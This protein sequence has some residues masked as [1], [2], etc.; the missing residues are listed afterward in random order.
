MVI[1]GGKRDK[2][3]TVMT[4]T[5]WKLMHIDKRKKKVVLSKV[6]YSLGYCNSLTSYKY[7]FKKLGKFI[8]SFEDPLLNPKQEYLRQTSLTN[9]KEMSSGN[10]LAVQQLA[11]H[12]FTAEGTSSI[13]GHGTK[14]PQR[15]ELCC[16]QV[17]YL[18]LRLLLLQIQIHNPLSTSIF[19]NKMQNV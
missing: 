7:F 19:P 11:L 16:L 1:R 8:S 10:S 9:L 13:P 17:K 4:R 12:T 15:N 5:M 2:K 18:K 14:I 3:I 6:S